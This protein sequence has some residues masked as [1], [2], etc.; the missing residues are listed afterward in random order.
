MGM[1]SALHRLKLSLST[2][3]NQMPYRY[4]KPARG[5]DAAKYGWKRTSGRTWMAPR[6][7]AW[8]KKTYVKRRP[9]GTVQSGLL[10]SKNRYQNSSL[11]MGTVPKVGTKDLKF[12]DVIDQVVSAVREGLGN[13]LTPAIVP[14]ISEVFGGINGIIQGNG[15][16]ERIASKIFLK[17]LI[18]KGIIGSPALPDAASTLFGVSGGYSGRILV[19]QDRQSNQTV[20]TVDG[21][22]NDDSLQPI[23]TRFINYSNTKRFKILADKTFHVPG[24]TAGI[25]TNDI[26][27]Q[28][29]RVDCEV[30]LSGITVVYDAESATGLVGDVVTNNIYVIYSVDHEIFEDAT[31]DVLWTSF[32]QTRVYYTG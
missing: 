17:K 16:S 12:Y 30:D 22:L 11:L 23:T 5:S 32:V 14:V 26:G 18:I 7:Q 20:A 10:R 4:N 29:T 1:P 25:L 28:M 19:V 15:V 2:Q 13:N 6:S 3:T 27:E 21:I 24:Q 9:M 31:D 8:K